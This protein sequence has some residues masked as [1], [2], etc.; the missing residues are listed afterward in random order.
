MT[1]SQSLSVP[2]L[3]TL[4]RTVG[5]LEAQARASGRYADTEQGRVY[6]G[7]PVT[8][9][10]HQAEGIFARRADKR[11]SIHLAFSDSV[12]FFLTRSGERLAIWE[13]TA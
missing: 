13:A 6:T 10:V 7:Q 9:V 4:N 8:V 12:S 5:V 3:E 11:V 1:G 2:Q